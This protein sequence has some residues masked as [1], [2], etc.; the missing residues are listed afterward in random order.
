MI[1]NQL[2]LFIIKKLNKRKELHV[3]FNWNPKRIILKMNQGNKHE[4]I[5]LNFQ[6]R[7]CAKIKK[8]AL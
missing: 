7:K 5:I 1:K 6:L 4:K 2:N 3:Q 8:Q